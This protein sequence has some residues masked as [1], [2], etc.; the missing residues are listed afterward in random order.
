MLVGPCHIKRNRAPHAYTARI[1]QSI[2][3]YHRTPTAAWSPPL[4]SL[5]SHTTVCETYSDRLGT[6]SDPCCDSD[7]LYITDQPTRCPRPTTNSC[8]TSRTTSK[9][10]LIDWP[11]RSKSPRM[12]PDSARQQGSV[13]MTTQRLWKPRVRAQVLLLPRYTS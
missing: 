5:L 9:T 10:T 1:L 4:S 8:S 11:E 3:G 12:C 13:L 7:P 2:I 6:R